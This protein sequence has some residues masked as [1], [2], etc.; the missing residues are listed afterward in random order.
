MGLK[1]MLS[2]FDV[3]GSSRTN[4]LINIF[5][6]SKNTLWM[7]PFTESAFSIVK[8]GKPAAELASMSI[9]EYPSISRTGII[10][11]QPVAVCLPPGMASVASKFRGD[12]TEDFAVSPFFENDTLVFRNVNPEGMY[13]HGELIH[14]S[15]K[16]LTHVLDACSMFGATPFYMEPF[17]M[18]IARSVPAE[19]EGRVFVFYSRD[20]VHFCAVAYGA[21][22]L[23]LSTAV[24]SG[25]EKY[26]WIIKGIVQGLRNAGI[27][28]EKKE[29]I[30]FSYGRV[31][32]DGLK[33]LSEKTGWEVS[34]RNT[35]GMISLR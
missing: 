19:E 3:L 22:V 20:S 10:N 31:D 29:I 32:D 35:A 6:G 28:K 7:I 17:W 18:N 24:G 1:E 27:S 23:Q 11:G 25:A 30:V 16:G 33:T 13:P 14:A 21:P 8:S 2:G 15:K 5:L 4:R 12:T 9:G 26:I 34:F